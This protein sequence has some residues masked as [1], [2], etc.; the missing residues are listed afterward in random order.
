MHSPTV[1]LRPRLDLHYNPATFRRVIAGKDV[2]I[3]CHHYNSRIQRTVEGAAEID[4]KALLHGAAEAVFADHLGRALTAGDDPS[5]PQAKN[6][7][8]SPS[9]PAGARPPPR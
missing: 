9:S 6:A 8:G 7:P 5:S 4:G 3:H 2:I 1:D